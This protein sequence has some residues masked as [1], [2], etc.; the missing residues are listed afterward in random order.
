MSKRVWGDV[1]FMH[2]RFLGLLAVQA[3]DGA[4]EHEAVIE[5]KGGVTVAYIAGEEGVSYAEAF[6]HENDN[7]NKTIG[8][9]IA[10][11][12]LAKGLGD[13]VEGVTVREFAE[14]LES[15]YVASG[16]IRTRKT[17]EKGNAA[18]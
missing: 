12:R 11:G 1:R 15:E 8:R 7:Y 16:L 18:A 14:R 3:E 2:F 13:V 17:K 6:C 9:F 10:S 5:G 4:L